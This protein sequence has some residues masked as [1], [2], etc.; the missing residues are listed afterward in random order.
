[1]GLVAQYCCDLFDLRDKH[2][3]FK[4]IVK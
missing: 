4:H 1:V 3:R 2:I